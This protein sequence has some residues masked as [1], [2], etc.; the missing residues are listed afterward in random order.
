[1]SVLEVSVSTLRQLALT[2]A[3]HV[4]T[5]ANIIPFLEVSSNQEYVVTRIKRKAHFICCCFT[6]K[7][8]YKSDIPPW[9]VTRYH[10][11]INDPALNPEK[12]KTHALE[13]QVLLCLLEGILLQMHI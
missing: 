9:R 8:Y 13:M 10:L 12:L 2:K 5:L 11:L 7:S 1:M 6:N 3:A 4:P